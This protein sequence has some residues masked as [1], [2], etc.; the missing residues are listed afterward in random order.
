MNWRDTFHRVVF[1][2]LE[3]FAGAEVINAAASADWSTVRSI[4]IAAAAAAATVLKEALRVAKNHYSQ[5]KQE[6]R[7]REQ[8]ASWS[9]A[10]ALVDESAEARL[11]A[12]LDLLEKRVNDL[13]GAEVP[14]SP[15]DPT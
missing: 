13:R 2:F 10:M 14:W 9:R 7:A 12:R 15:E 4:A 1:T 3:A 5:V 6:T 11:T 8:L